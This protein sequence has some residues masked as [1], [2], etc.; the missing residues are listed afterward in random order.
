MKSAQSLVV[1]FV[2]FRREVELQSFYSA[3]LISSPMKSVSFASMTSTTF[4]KEFLR[5]TLWD[6]SWSTFSA[7]HGLNKHSLKICCF[8]YHWWCLSLLP[9]SV[10]SPWGFL[11]IVSYHQHKGT[12]LL[13]HLDAFY[14]FFFCLIAVA[15]CSNTMWNN[16]GEHGHLCLIPDFSGKAFSFSP[17]N[18]LFCCGFVINGC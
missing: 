15:G 18:I 3:I 17:L 6:H 4:K 8:C 10:I 1:N 14:F 7:L 13:F 9:S 11:L 5:S 2:V 12:I 16:G